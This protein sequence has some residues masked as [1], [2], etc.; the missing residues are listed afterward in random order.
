MG[1]VGV[2]DRAHRQ[3]RVAVGP[4]RQAGRSEQRAGDGHAPVDLLAGV[5]D[6]AGVDE[7]D[8]RVADQTGVDTEV[9][10]V[11]EVTEH[12]VRR[13]PMPN[14][15]VAP[16]GIS[17]AT[18]GAIA[19]SSAIGGRRPTA[20]GGRSSWTTAASRSAGTTVSPNVNGT[21]GLTSPIVTRACADRRLDVVGDQAERVLAAGVGALSWTNTTST[22]SWPPTDELGSEPKWTG[23]HASTPAF[24]SA[25]VRP[26]PPNP[27]N[28]KRVAV[29][30]PEQP[31]ERHA[32]EHPQRGE[33]VALLDQRLDE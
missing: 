5:G 26:A 15:I 8:E 14:W 19:S 27:M 2:L 7:V 12:G 11:V 4:R 1:V 32:D 30:R 25:A 29:L 10:L 3:C 22:G 31:A 24:V 13:P 16:S 20:T 23:M 17:S 21:C 6:D 28:S 33:V 9:A 18:R